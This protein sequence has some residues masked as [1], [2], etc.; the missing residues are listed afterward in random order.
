MQLVD[1]H[2]AASFASGLKTELLNSAALLSVIEIEKCVD[3]LDLM[4]QFWHLLAF[5]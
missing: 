4:T 2:F 1:M 3:S 5:L